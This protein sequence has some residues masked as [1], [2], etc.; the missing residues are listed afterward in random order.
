[1]SEEKP[2]VHVV[3]FGQAREQKLDEKRRK[4]ERIFFTNLLSVYSVVGEG[5][6][7]PIELLEVSEDGLSFQVPFD[8][9]DPWPM[10][11]NEMPLR[12][13]FS[14]DTYIPIHIKIE[15]SRSLIDKG[16][17]YTRYGCSI[18]KTTQSYEAF[19]QFTRFMKSYSEHA[20]RDKGD[21]SVFYL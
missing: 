13:Y 20:H 10:G 14:Q 2:G 3:D 17:R 6:I 7:R 11:S 16:A 15:N 21:V 19:I 12:L 5:K 18:D 1:M 9:R 4:T 8:S